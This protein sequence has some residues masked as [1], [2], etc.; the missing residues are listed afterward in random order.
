L[1][2]DDVDRFRFVDFY[3][4]TNV[5]AEMKSVLDGYV[6]APIEGGRAIYFDFLK[7]KSLGELNDHLDSVARG[8]NKLL[9]NDDLKEASVGLRTGEMYGDNKMIG[10][11]VRSISPE[12]SQD[13]SSFVNAVQK[14]M[15]TGS[16]GTV[17]RT[18][19]AAWHAVNVGETGG[20]KSK[21]LQ[22]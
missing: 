9:A 4:R 12:H 7:S 22:T 10:F 20:A 16:Y 21:I 17:S 18:Q 2:G 1:Q 5:T 3:R 13:W 19:L 15:L 8:G 14:G 11:E 6:L